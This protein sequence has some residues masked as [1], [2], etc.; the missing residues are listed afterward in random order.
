MY[1]SNKKQKYKK[2]LKVK[3]DPDLFFSLQVTSANMW[4]LQSRT[5]R[6]SQ[7]PNWDPQQD[8]KP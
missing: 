8:F 6:K 2:C 4:Y 5:R 7:T 1:Y 3:C